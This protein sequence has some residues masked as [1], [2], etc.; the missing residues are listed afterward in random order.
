MDLP[1]RSGCPLN[2]AAEVLGDPWA[3]LV[4]RDIMV[5]DRRHFCELIAGPEEGIAT[6]SA[7]QSSALLIP[8]SAY[9]Y[10]VRA[11]RRLR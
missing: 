4:L 9:G 3:M 6:N 7:P 10:R 8:S 5:G 1:P 11:D 2:A